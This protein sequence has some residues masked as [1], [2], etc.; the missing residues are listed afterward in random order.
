MNGEVGT[1]GTQLAVVDT[2]PIETKLQV[3]RNRAESIEVVNQESYTLACQ[4]ALDGRKEVKAIGF[5][6]DPGIQSAREHL[7]ELRR[8]KAAFV[9]R[10]TPIIELASG[11]A[12]AWKAEERRKAAAEEERINA[13][14]RREAARIAEE[15]RRKAE[16]QAEIDRKK[17][18]AEVEVARQQREKDLEEQR[19]LGEINKRE[20]ERQKKLA[21][22]EAERQRQ[23]AIED[24]ARARELAAEQAEE[25]KAN[26]QEVKVK[27]SV[28]T[29]AG[30]KA[31]VNWKFRVIN[32]SMLPR[33]YL[34]PDEVAIGQEVRRLKDKAAAEAK[35]PGIEVYSEDSI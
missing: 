4:I 33:L 23:E 5:V 12:E 13:E 30:I 17:R 19:R 9:D 3:L 35:I 31:R 8:Q 22:A 20:M 15:E 6:L 25:A 34:M 11:K 10:V 2:K 32:P 7:D 18:E 1:M 27:A 29:V 26:F 28:P 24:A 14:R 21:A 16:A